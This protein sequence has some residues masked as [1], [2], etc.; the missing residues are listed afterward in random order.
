MP[1]GPGQYRTCGS[2]PVSTPNGVYAINSQ[3]AIANDIPAVALTGLYALRRALIYPALACSQEGRGR[4][5]RVKRGR[6]GA[7]PYAQFHIRMLVHTPGWDV[8]IDWQKRPGVFARRR[9]WRK[10][11]PLHK[12]L[13][14]WIGAQRI[15]RRIHFERG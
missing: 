11:D 10:L 1:I 6:D 13:K 14:T 15:K 3:L 8:H 9:L 12:I 5:A 7:L 4:W 2:V